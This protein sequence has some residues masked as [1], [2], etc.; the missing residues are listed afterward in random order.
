[1]SKVRGLEY[2]SHLKTAPLRWALAFGAYIKPGK[3]TNVL[4]YFIYI[5]VMKEKV[6]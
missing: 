5:S 1:V 6:L 4:A 2:R 3:E